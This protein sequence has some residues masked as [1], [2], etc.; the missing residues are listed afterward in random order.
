[1]MKEKKYK[2]SKNVRKKYK[3]KKR[4]LKKATKK[5]VQRQ[6]QLQFNIPFSII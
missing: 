4:N 1:M 3:K 6:N 5:I 2:K